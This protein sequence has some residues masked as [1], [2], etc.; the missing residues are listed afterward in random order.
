MKIK[1]IGH[2]VLWSGENVF[3]GKVREIHEKLL[4]NEIVLANVVENVNI[5]Q[6]T[7][8]VKGSE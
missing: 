8:F 2:R 4:E 5:A 3:D 7:Y 6:F 1:N